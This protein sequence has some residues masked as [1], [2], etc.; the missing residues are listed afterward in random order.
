MTL[1]HTD[2]EVHTIIAQ[3]QQRQ[4]LKLSL[5]PSENF[6]SASVREAVG[7]VFMHKYAEGNIKK[8]YYEG[9][10]FVDKLESLTIRRAKKAFKLPDEWSVN[11]QALAGSNANLAVYLALLDIGDTMMG[12]FLP[13]GGHLSHG[14]SYEPKTVQDPHSYIYFGGSR[15]VNITSRIFKTIQYKTSPLTQQFD[16]D[17]V[18]QIAM[19]HKPKL[20][21]TGGTAYPREIDYHRMKSIAQKVGA[22]YMADI[23]HEAGLIAAGAMK[24]PIGIADVVTM[25]THKTL[26]SGRGAL[27][28]AHNDIIKKINRAVL[29]GLQGGPFNHSIAGICVGLGEVLKPEFKEYAFQTVRNAQFLVEELKRY[30]FTIVSGGTDKHLILLNLTNKPILGKKFARALDYA[31]IV[32]NMNTMPQE[33]RSPADPSALRIGTPWITTR[34]MKEQEMVQIAS[35]INRVM[36][37]CSPWKEYEFDEFEKSVKE[38][39]EIQTISDEVKELCLKFPLK[40]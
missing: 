13:D 8:R 15:K 34:G 31:G 11:V 12:M 3:E 40:I 27:I 17:E 2:P 23:A 14:W 4:Q 25:T 24:S 32:A 5:I 36:E 19:E 22:Y 29:P 38:S 6:F 26:R 39:V 33:I 18:E 30:N 20:I 7:S 10:V 1:H 37:I 21:I 35:W 16:Y 9:N 28:F